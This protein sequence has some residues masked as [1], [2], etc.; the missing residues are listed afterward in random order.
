MTNSTARSLREMAGCIAYEWRILKAAYH[1]YMDLRS[2]H[3]Q[4]AE[5]LPKIHGTNPES[6]QWMPFE[7]S[8]V[9][10]DA[11]IYLEAF[12]L[13]ARVLYGFLFRAPRKSDAAPSDFLA[14]EHVWA[15]DPAKTCPKLSA[16]IDRIDKMLA[17][18]TWKRP[19][20]IQRLEHSWSVE[21]YVT[22]LR[23]AYREFASRLIG[24][25][26]RDFQE[27]VQRFIELP[28]FLWPLDA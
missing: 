8:G 7:Q 22:E 5:L 15:A 26:R 4:G 14:P 20:F 3:V 11:C 2:S 1:R 28:W 18:L 25:E 24:E 16:D 27:G 12:L 13:H 10:F 19:E 17:H 23:G 6:F 21:A 9:W